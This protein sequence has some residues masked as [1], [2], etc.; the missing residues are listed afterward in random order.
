MSRHTVG[1][2]KARRLSESS[3]LLQFSRCSYCTFTTF[4]LCLRNVSI[5]IPFVTSRYNIPSPAGTRKYPY[6]PQKAPLILN[7]RMWPAAR[8]EAAG[9]AW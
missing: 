6:E 2:K 9:I 5:A 1:N 7:L 8:S 3:L 4:P